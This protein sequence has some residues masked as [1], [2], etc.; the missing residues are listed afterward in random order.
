MDISISLIILWHLSLV[1]NASWI[2]VWK[3]CAAMDIGIEI[4]STDL[5]IFL[6]FNSLM[7]RHES[8]VPH[9]KSK[10]D[11]NIIILE[12]KQQKLII[13]KKKNRKQ[14]ENRMA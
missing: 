12:M 2:R 13:A 8:S 6:S 1:K 9:F 4:V 7:H 3:S 11:H 10:N 5:R 14:K